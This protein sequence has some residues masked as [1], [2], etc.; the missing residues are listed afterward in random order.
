MPRSGV[1]IPPHGQQRV[2]EGDTETG[3]IKAKL[4]RNEGGESR[5][6]ILS[7]GEAVGR[8]ASWKSCHS[9]ERSELRQ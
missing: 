1:H 8:Q 2:T 7:W 3:T 6:A 4:Q 9:P 5:W